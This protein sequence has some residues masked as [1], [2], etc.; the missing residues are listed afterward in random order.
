MEEKLPRLQELGATV[1]ANVWGDTEDDYVAVVGARIGDDPTSPRSSS[2]SP[3]RTSR[4]AGWSSATRRPRRPRSCRASAPRRAGRSSSSSRRTSPTSSSP[5]APPVDAGADVLSLVNTFVGMAIDPVT[6]RAR[7][8]AS[9]TGGLSGPAIKPLA[10]RMVFEVARALPG[11]PIFGIGG[12][13]TVA[14]VL[15]FLVAGANAV[16]IGT[17]NFRD[18]GVCGTARRR[19]RGVLP[20]SEDHR[21]GARRPRA[22]LDGADR[23]GSGRRGEG[24]KRLC[25]ALDFADA[26][27]DPGGRAAVRAPKVGC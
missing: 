3:A 24:R 1:I 27:T 16:Q 19:A 21:G 20:G 25:V 14:D 2:T 10:L 6:A 26:A 8:S 9:A 7:R 4:R 22:A 23:R 17:A 12:I 15:E 5:R 11:V 18:P 13:E